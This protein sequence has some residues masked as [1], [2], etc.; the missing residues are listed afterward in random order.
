MRASRSLLAERVL[1]L[2]EQCT[3]GKSVL[4]YGVKLVCSP[5]QSDLEV[6]SCVSGP[7][8]VGI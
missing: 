6:R 7:I 8:T 4:I 2:S 3:M 1:P 5:P